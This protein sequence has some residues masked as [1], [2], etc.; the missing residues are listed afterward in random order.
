MAD[1]CSIG[2]DLYY[3]NPDHSMRSMVKKVDYIS[4]AGFLDGGNA[5]EQLGFG[6]GPQAVISNLAVMDF[7]P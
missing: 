1:M 3:W 2:K 4:G 5:R 7:H 6:G